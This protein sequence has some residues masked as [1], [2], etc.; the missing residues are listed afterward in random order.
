MSHY[1]LG[2]R[3]L[4]FGYQ[5]IILWV[6]DLSLLVLCMAG[7]SVTCITFNVKDKITVYISPELITH[8]GVHCC[9]R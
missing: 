6:P 2:T 3:P 5:T 8:C 1:T 4:Y 9:I 7:L